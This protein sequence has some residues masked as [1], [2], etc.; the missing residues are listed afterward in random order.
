MIIVYLDLDPLPERAEPLLDPFEDAAEPDL[1]RE[2][3]DPD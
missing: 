2:C 1:L 3:C